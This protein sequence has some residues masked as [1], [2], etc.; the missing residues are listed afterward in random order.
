MKAMIE[1]RTTEIIA[2]G[3]LYFGFAKRYVISPKKTTA[4]VVWPEGKEYP[5]SMIRFEIGR[6]TWK[7]FFR[8]LIAMAVTMEVEAR[9]I[10]LDFCLLK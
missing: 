8:S 10:A 6:S 5:V 7:R 9:K 4:N 3:I 2:A 1:T